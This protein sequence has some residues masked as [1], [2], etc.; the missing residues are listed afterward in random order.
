MWLSE[1]LRAAKS[2]LVFG[3]RVSVERVNRLLLT[4]AAAA[5][6]SRSNDMAQMEIPFKAANVQTRAN[7]H[8]IFF[9]FFTIS[10]IFFT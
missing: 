5:W 4:V 6:R 8:T 3:Y 7:M 2:S 1:Y 10:Q 9:F